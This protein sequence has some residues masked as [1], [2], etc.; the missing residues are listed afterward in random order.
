MSVTLMSK[1]VRR[2]VAG[3]ISFTGRAGR[4]EYWWVTLFCVLV[5]IGLMLIDIAL[6]GWDYRFGLADLWMIVTLVPLLAVGAR[7]LHDIGRSGWWQLIALVPVF[8]ALVLI[9]WLAKP[10][11]PKGNAYGKPVAPLARL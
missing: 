11:D 5:A 8:G 2:A 7:R 6:Q 9:V 1:A 4:G 3:A 10:S